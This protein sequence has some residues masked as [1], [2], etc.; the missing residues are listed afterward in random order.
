VKGF[1]FLIL[2]VLILIQ[3]LSGQGS[4]IPV[5][6]VLY[7]Y[8]ENALF[9]DSDFHTSVKPWVYSD[10]RFD[11]S[12]VQNSF[13]TS[14]GKISIRP[15]TETGFRYSGDFGK[16]MLFV[17]G[18]SIRYK[19]SGKFSIKASI[20]AGGQYFE[21]GTNGFD[22]LKVLPYC[23]KWFSQSEKIYFFPAITGSINYK[24]GNHFLFQAGYDRNFVGNGYRSVLLSEN[25]A[26]Y[27]FVKINF[28]SWRV[29]YFIMWAYLNDIS[30]NGFT[31]KYGVF[32]YL[33][34]NLTR[35]LSIG[36]YES[37]IW[38]GSDANTVR[39][40]DPA[41]LNPVIFF[42]PIEYSIHSPDNANIGGNAS[43]RLGKRSYLYGQLYLDDLM[44]KELLK[45]SGWWGNKYA[46]Q[47]GFRTSKAYGEHQ[48]S[49]LTEINM[50]RPY[51]YSHTSTTLN[52]GTL[53]GSLA[54]PLGANFAEGVGIFRYSNHSWYMM[55]KI[56]L[57]KVGLDTS[58][59][60]LGQ[61][62]YKSY[63]LR[64]RKNDYNVKLWQGQKEILKWSELRFG[65][66]LDKNKHF[67]LYSVMGIYSK[68]SFSS[69]DV[70]FNI[71]LST[72]IFNNERD[73]VLP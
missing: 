22:T 69:K 73:I 61:D 68:G 10:E 37:V 12:V 60:N 6:S 29:N 20:M 52:Y 53:Y 14:T 46:M 49:L 28:Q 9:V 33:D 55:T 25:S 56:V 66:W 48:V 64:N 18:A 3:A 63:N 62:I 47:F 35:R 70:F 51:T 54:H 16:Q 40:I 71:G 26:P 27:P 8:A 34:I 23:G 41:Y 1:V 4:T 59:V 31:D 43:L 44:V 67:S 57:A 39:G 36:F 5:N 42:R 13:I 72:A 11:T 30:D 7:L 38:W 50:A 58:I 15:E 24:P 19:P 45:N 2:Y 65:K 17:E 21:K 32:H